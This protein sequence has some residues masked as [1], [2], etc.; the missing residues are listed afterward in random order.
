MPLNRVTKSLLKKVPQALKCLE[1]Q[2]TQVPQVSVHR[3]YRVPPECLQ[4]V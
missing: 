4:S 1:Y 3:A 2:S